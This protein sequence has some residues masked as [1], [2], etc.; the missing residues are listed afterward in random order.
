MSIPPPT[1]KNLLSDVNLATLVRVH[2][3]SHRLDLWVVLVSISSSVTGR[4]LR[5]RG[6]ARLGFLTVK[7]IDLTS[8][9]HVGKHEILQD[10]NSLRRSC[11]IIVLERIKEVFRSACPVTCRSAREQWFQRR[12][13]TTD[14]RPSTSCHHTP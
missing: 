13:D 5:R 3:V 12:S 9:K 1:A 4:C 14:V 6:C 11:L 10:L 2:Q 7:W 8:S